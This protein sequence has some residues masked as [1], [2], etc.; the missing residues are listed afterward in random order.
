MGRPLHEV[1]LFQTPAISFALSAEE[2][3]SRLIIPRSSQNSHSRRAPGFAEVEGSVGL[4][5]EDSDG[6]ITEASIGRLSGK[7]QQVCLP[8]VSF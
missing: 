4:R 7:S 3:N 1:A 2:S 8:L 6:A 5:L